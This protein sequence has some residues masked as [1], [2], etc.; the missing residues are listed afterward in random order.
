MKDAEKFTWFRFEICD[1]FIVSYSWWK[2]SKK[3]FWIL[4]LWQKLQYDSAYTRT[5]YKRNGHIATLENGQIK[6]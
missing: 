1:F 4:P 3:L 5:W 2:V 6:K